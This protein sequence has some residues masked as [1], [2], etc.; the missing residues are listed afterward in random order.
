MQITLKKKLPYFFC[1]LFI[2]LLAQEIDTLQHK[3]FVELDQLFHSTKHSATPDTLQCIAYANAYFKKALQKKDTIKMLESQYLITDIKNDEN[4]YLNFCDSLIDLTH[5]RPCKNFPAKIH[6]HKISYYI[7]ARQDS[8]AQQEIL[9]AN[10]SLKINKNTDLQNIVNIYTGML[11]GRLENYQECIDLLK[12]SYEYGVKND[13]IEKEDIYLNLPT[14]IALGYEKLN[15]I[16]SAHV[17][18]NKAIQLYEKLN[19]KLML[20]VTYIVKARIDLR[21]NNYAKAID[22]YKKAVPAIIEDEYYD[23]LSKTY[24]S[25]AVNYDSLNN[26]KNALLYHRKVD[27]LF[28]INGIK[29]ESI[30]SSY[31]YLINDAKQKRDLSKQ[32]A[33]TENFIKIKEYNLNERNKLNTTFTNEYDIPSLEEEKESLANKI[34]QQKIQKIIFILLMLAFLALFIYQNKKRVT[35]KKQFQKILNQKE[36]IKEQKKKPCNKSN[37]GISD[38]VVDEILKKLNGFEEKEQYLRQN[39]SLSS[40][41]NLINTNSSYLSK[42]INHHKNTTFTNYINELRINYIVERL[43]NDARLR[44][45]TIK[46]IATEIGFKNDESF[47]RAFYKYTNLKPSYFIKELDKAIENA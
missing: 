22:N 46:A 1:F 12:K 9:L 5:K 47:S 39:I 44:R 2:S 11:K 25:I 34:Q 16:D 27:S 42:V 37:Q 33:Y 7:S 23:L 26:K 30:E 38:A 14:N 17:Y 10:K 31:I 13:L 19:D 4:F 45:Y 6:I 8:K 3:S 28:N 20:G 43:K 35:Y 24:T 18:L 40:V 36:F 29:N 15:K 21:D 32:L 41:A